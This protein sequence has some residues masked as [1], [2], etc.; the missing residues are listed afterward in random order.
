MKSVLE[1]C[2]NVYEY[3]YIFTHDI[4]VL[5]TCCDEMQCGIVLTCIMLV[6]MTIKW[7]SFLAWMKL[8]MFVILV[9]EVNVKAC[10]LMI[11]LISMCEVM[12]LH[13]CIDYVYQDWDCK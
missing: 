11:G 8:S 2:S 3:V 4:V 9:Y 10:G 1:R 12:E 13:M 6:L 7:R 5:S